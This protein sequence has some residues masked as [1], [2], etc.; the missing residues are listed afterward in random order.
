MVDGKLWPKTAPAPALPAE[1]IDKTAE[2]Y[3]EALARLTK[4]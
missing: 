2:K 4:A 1:V 3:R